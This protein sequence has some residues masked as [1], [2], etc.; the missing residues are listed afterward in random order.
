MTLAERYATT[1][2]A[3]ELH[4]YMTFRAQREGLTYGLD[5]TWFAGYLKAGV[6]LYFGVETTDKRIIRDEQKPDLVAEWKKS[7][8]A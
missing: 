4:Q 1:T 3:E 5:A 6:R 7:I 2:L 8:A